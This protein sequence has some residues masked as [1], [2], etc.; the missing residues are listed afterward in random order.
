V[1]RHHVDIFFGHGWLNEIG[2]GIARDSFV[3]VIH[4]WL[5]VWGTAIGY[6]LLL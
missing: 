3:A 6:Y 2:D 1:S 4:Q 5:V